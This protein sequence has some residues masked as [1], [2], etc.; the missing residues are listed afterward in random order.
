MACQVAESGHDEGGPAGVVQACDHELRLQSAGQLRVNVTE[1]RD[2]PLDDVHGIDPA[3]QIGMGLGDLQPDPCPL[4]MVAGAGQRLVKSVAGG[5][6]SGHRLHPRQFPQYGQL[7][8][9]R[10]RLGPCPTEQFRGLLGG[11]RREH[12][13]RRFPQPVA[14][15]GVSGRSQ[16]AKV[17]GHVARRS[18]IGV[19]QGRRRP[20]Q[21]LAL[22]TVQ[23]H[24]DRVPQDRMDKAR[25]I[26]VE[27]HLRV[28]QRH[29]RP[30]RLVRTQACQHRRLT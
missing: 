29:H 4:P 2:R 21:H 24:L 7:V 8:L 6:A 12:R 22:V 18:P 27:Q 14:H 25:R 15:P 23:R 19:Q 26:R 30:E 28:H 13:G 9:H 20:M 17:R 16:A 1:L 10:R 3:E 5:G 11:S